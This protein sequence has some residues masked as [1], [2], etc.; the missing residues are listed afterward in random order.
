MVAKS[1][2]KEALSGNSDV[3]GVCPLCNGI[4]K[5]GAVSP[6]NPF[7]KLLLNLFCGFQLPLPL[8]PFPFHSF[9][10]FFPLHLTNLTAN[11][12]ALS[13]VFPDFTRRSISS[14][15]IL[16]VVYCYFMIKFSNDLF[17][18][19]TR[20]FEV[21]QSVVDMLMAL[22]L[23]RTTS[24]APL[25]SLSSRVATLPLCTCSLIYRAIYPH[26][27]VLVYRATAMRQTC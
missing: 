15:L 5:S 12:T 27:L 11:S 18:L 23:S 22:I 17:M 19:L 3:T 7:G 14:E 4:Y 9:F 25:N 10:S 13:N 6:E 26:L 21:T 16:F 20:G 2:Y 24:N 1:L 8:S